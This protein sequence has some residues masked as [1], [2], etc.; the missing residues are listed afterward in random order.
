MRSLAQHV[1]T[2]A[3]AAALQSWP[4]GAA[5]SQVPLVRTHAPQPTSGPISAADL[6]TRLYLFADDSMMGRLVGSPADLMGTTY[7]ASELTR[8]GLHGGGD[9]GTFFQ[10]IPL[11]KSAV[12]SLAELRLGS[13]RFV[14]GK[15]YVPIDNSVWGR[16]PVAKS[17]KL[18]FG[19]R[20]GG[21]A[22]AQLSLFGRRRRCH[23]RS[24]G[25]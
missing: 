9:G 6:M 3:V 10:S 22:A 14:L 12:V 24:R 1:T 5:S 15:D 20:D 11:Y 17:A 2:V 13:S 16:S 4:L 7:I 8:L 19:G 18:V 23:H 25:D 21:G